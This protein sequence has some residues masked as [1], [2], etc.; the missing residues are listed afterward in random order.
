ML[1]KERGG[2]GILVNRNFESEVENNKRIISEEIFENL[3]FRI[4]NIIKTGRV[5]SRKDLVIAAIYRQSDNSNLE[6]FLTEMENL[7]SVI[8][9]RK[10]EIIIAGD[11]N[12]ELLRYESH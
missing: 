4:P 6:T 1:N 9:K 3:V 12:L 11:M 5:N 7:R 10:K 2:V 8:D